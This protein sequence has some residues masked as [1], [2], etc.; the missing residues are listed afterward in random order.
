MSAFLCMI[1][2]RPKIEAPYKYNSV[3]AIQSVSLK[4]SET[5]N[6]MW[7]ADVDFPKEYNHNVFPNLNQTMTES[8][9][10]SPQTY[11][12]LFSTYRV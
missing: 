6:S 9:L 12:S 5:I 11:S 8:R 10:T 1:F 7:T 4:N 2:K 3:V